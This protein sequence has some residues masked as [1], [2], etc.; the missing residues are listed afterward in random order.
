MTPNNSRLGP[1]NNATFDPDVRGSVTYSHNPS[2]PIPV[3]QSKTS[4]VTNP[5]CE[6]I[7]NSLLKPHPSSFFQPHHPSLEQP[8][9]SLI[10]NYSFPI[11]NG[12]EVH[13]LVNDRIYNVSDTAY[14]TLYAIQENAAWTPPAPEQR[15]LMII[16]D[17]YRGKTVRIV[18]QSSGG[19]GSH[20]FHMHGHGF[21]VVASGAGPFD[22]TA[23]ALANAVDLR[24]VV[25][26]DTVTVPSQ[27]WVVTQYVFLQ[28]RTIL[29]W[30]LTLWSFLDRI[31]ADNPGVWALHCH[32]GKLL[33]SPFV[34]SYPLPFFT[35]TNPFTDF[36]FIHGMKHAPFDQSYS[37]PSHLFFRSRLHDISAL[38]LP[39]YSVLRLD[40]CG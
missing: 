30:V 12:A 36:A 39:A 3:P 31:T 27:G 19:H 4:N 26:R 21:Q 33:N 24:S 10:L 17:A 1:P 40:D 2:E 34:L 5:A 35:A 32:V 7:D 38:P 16:P 20:P 18:I 13:T 11:V 9:L 23:L 6:D 29:R 25:A 37:V 28:Y 14:P 22:N 8:S 15:N